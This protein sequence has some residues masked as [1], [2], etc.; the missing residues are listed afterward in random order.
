MERFT[1][2]HHALLFAWISRAII[3]TAG[4]KE[5]QRIV[6]KAVINMRGQGEKRPAG[7]SPVISTPILTGCRDEDQNLLKY[8]KKPSAGVCSANLA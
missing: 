2:I 3:Q 5:G 7:L 1:A 4:E 8:G 6:R